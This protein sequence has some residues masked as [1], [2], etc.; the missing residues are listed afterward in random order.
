MLLVGV[1]IVLVVV[2]TSL[3]PGIVAAGAALAALWWGEAALMSA[4]GLFVSPVMP[5]IGTLSSLAVMTLV[6][7]T[8]ERSRAEIANRDKTTTQRLMVQALLSLTETRDAETG[9]HSRRTQQ[10][11][12][13]LADPL[14][15]HPAFRD[16]LTADRIDLLSRL[17][18]LH[19]IGKVGIPD[20]VLN[21][22]GPLTPE[23]AAGQNGA[24]GGEAHRG[25]GLSVLHQGL[26]SC[27]SLFAKALKITQSDRESLVRI[28][29]CRLSIA[30]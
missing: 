13:L 2:R 3:L 28:F 26:K 9:R 16:Y 29:D 23:E 24:G 14:G 19:D 22:P 11:A 1:G 17:A 20:R 25:R 15:A 27:N 7:F 18:P 30:D 21:K 10:Y 12:R 5:T 8:A 6:T 4:S